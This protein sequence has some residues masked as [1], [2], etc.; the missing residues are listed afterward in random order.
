MAK[1]TIHLRNRLILLID[2]V[3]ISASVAASFAMRLELGPV[4]AYY[5]TQMILMILLALLIKPAVFYYF[6]LYRR[7][8]AYASIEELRLIVG[9]NVVASAFL[10]VAVFLMT[11]L[12]SAFN[13]FPGFP[14]SSIAIDWIVSILF[15]GGFRFSLRMLSESRLAQVQKSEVVR[16]VAIA[17]A[18]SAGTLVVRELQ[19]NQQL[20]LNPVAFL[21]DDP[22]KI[23]KQLYGIPVE[24]KLSD[25]PQVVRDKQ[26]DEVIIAIPSAPGSVV[27]QVSEACRAVGVRFR[28]MPGIYELLGG[29]VNVSRL[30]KV[31]ITDLLRREPARTDSE[32]VGLTL[33]GKSVLIT[34][35]GGSIGMELCRQVARWGPAEI[36]LLGHG[37]NSIFEGVLE[38]QTAYPSLPLFPIIADIRDSNRLY[39][40]FERYRPQVVFHAAAHKHVILMENNVEEAITNNILGT[41]NVMDAAVSFDVE[42]LVMISTD[43]A[44]RP[45]SVM[46]A[47]KRIAEMLVVD[48]ANRIGKPYSVVRFGNVLGSR[49]SIVPIF[50]S[51]IENGGPVT[52]THPEMRRFF[53]T[54][55]EAVHLVLHAGALGQ[56]GEVFILNMG[57][58]IKVLDLAEDLIRLSGLEPGKDI[59]IVFTG[60]RSGEKLSE[61]LWDARSDVQ[62]TLHPEILRMVRDEPVNGQ[63]LTQ[64]VGELIYLAREGDTANILNLLDKVVPGST[65]STTPPP[66]L[67]SVA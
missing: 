14:R 8:W 24:G 28:T 6:G 63:K 40:V 11:T 2:L 5:F 45:T 18:G 62:R 21:D 48:T 39:S 30:R 16:N 50:Q 3:L 49:G 67:I 9:A 61:E 26:I 17:G 65:V 66:D 58:Q 57:E 33:N 54:I 19:K 31:Q 12:Q 64:I 38:L 4:F 60:A 7:L 13:I 46:G 59:E 27:R 51:Q 47:T 41:R 43:K 44:V 42:R 10:A 32:K 36:V 1:E 22:S 53:M 25:L 20:G 29:Q 55:P 52:V 37:E 23:G 34:G 15:I 35:A 56:G